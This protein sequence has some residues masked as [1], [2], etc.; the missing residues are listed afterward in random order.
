LSPELCFVGEGPGADEDRIGEPFVGPSGQLLTRIIAAM[1]LTREAVYICNTV[2]CRPP[3]NRNPS[4]Q[5]CA[6]CRGFFEQQIEQVQPRFICCLGA[7]AAQN[8]LQSPLGIGQLRGRLHDYRGIPV[9]CTYH[10][11]YLLRDPT[12]KKD[13]WD[14]MK[15]LLRHMGRPIPG[16]K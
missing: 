15:A 6:N 12:R 10:P 2:K 14:D 7:V 8:V 1:G 11:A 13:C 16:E 4:H 5:E 9:L 3:M